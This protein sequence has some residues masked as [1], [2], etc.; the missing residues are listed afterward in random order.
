MRLAT[1]HDPV[2]LDELRQLAERRLG[3]MV[4]ALVDLGR[5]LML[6]LVRR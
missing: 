6:A 1:E 3:D 2:S 4:K 5:G